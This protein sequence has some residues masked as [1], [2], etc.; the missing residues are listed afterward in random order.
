MNRIPARFLAVAVCLAVG[1]SAISLSRQFSDRPTSAVEV[2]PETPVADNWN[3]V[4][5]T[6]KSGEA[7]V[8]VLERTGVPKM[9][10]TR[11]LLASS[12]L[13]ARRIRAGTA[14][15]TRT[16]ADSGAT[17]IVFHMAIDRLVRLSRPNGAAEWT[18]SE[19]VLPWTVDTVAVGGMVQS[20]L[21]EAIIDGAEAF[22]SNVRAEVAYALADILEYRV[23]LSRDLQKNDTVLVLMERKVAPTGAVR[24][25]NILAA[26]LTVAGNRVETVRF[27]SDKSPMQYFD[28][29]GKSMRAAFLRAPLAFRRI[30]SV[31]GRRKHPILGVWRAH[32]GT[33]YSAAAGTPVRALGDGT[34]IFAGTKGG[35]G[36][37]LEIRHKNGMV[38]RY[39]HLRGFA[40][41][42]RRG[43]TVKISNTIGYVG[44]T[45]L[46]TAPHL[47]FEVLIGGVHRDPRK[48][49]S[50]QSG[51]PIATADKLAFTE[52]KSQLFARLERM[53]NGMPIVAQDGSFPP[54]VGVRGDA[55]RQ[56][57]DE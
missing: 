25:G 54:S 16:R 50:S 53:L 55:A 6:V 10:A 40:A 29:D 8:S 12:R 14:I 13:D 7:V 41:G 35:Y 56:A 19:E 31:F 44:A 22:P 5:D 2:G 42:I 9:E 11:A 46:A 39:A 15:T 49:L 33:D 48:A 4:T 36:R 43:T 45:G 57:G 32:Q 23:D 3:T 34:I 26:R 18:E 47:H 21:V 28:G 51:E 52:L 38:T 24:P 17:E 27:E 1:V 30:S 20:T 37:T